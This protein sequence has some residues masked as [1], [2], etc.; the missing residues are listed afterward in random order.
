MPEEYYELEVYEYSE[1]F[2]PEPPKG[3][4]YLVKDFWEEVPLLNL[5][6]SNKPS[7]NTFE[8]EG[9]SLDCVGLL[10]SAN[11][12]IFGFRLFAFMHFTTTQQYFIYLAFRLSLCALRLAV[13]IPAI[14]PP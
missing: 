5:L 1:V 3:G 11:S 8:K 4:L 2:N 14:S 6:S 9:E 13:F 12:N 10:Y 7:E